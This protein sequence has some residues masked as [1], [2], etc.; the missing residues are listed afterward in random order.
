MGPFLCAGCSECRPGRGVLPLR[1]SQWAVNKYL[2]CSFLGRW[3]M[4]GRE[5][6]AGPKAVEIEWL[7]DKSRHVF[8][9]EYLLAPHVSHMSV[10]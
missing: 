10:L 1:G 8:L 4:G 6:G 9:T 7:Y 2:V 3:G 5:S